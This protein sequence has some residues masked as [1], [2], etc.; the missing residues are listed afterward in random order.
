MVNDKI[1]NPNH[2][3]GNN[4]LEAIEVIE[5]FAACPEYVEG[6]YWGNAMK[7][8]LR[9]HKKN[10]IEDLKKARQNLN[11]LIGALERNDD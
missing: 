3:Q 5:Q 2:Y 10:G 7:Y 8:M 11:W 1:N 6:F 9:F 4:G